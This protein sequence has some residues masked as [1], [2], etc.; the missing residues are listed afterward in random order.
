VT[1]IPGDG[2][3]PEVAE[4]TR[5]VLDASGAAFEWDLQDA[6]YE[7]WEREGT[8]VPDSTLASLRTRRLALKGPTKTPLGGFRPVN[9][10]FRREFDLYAGVR[11]SRAYPGVPTRFPETD[12]V[13]VRMTHEDLYAGIEYPR[14]EAATAELRELVER[15]DGAQIP[16]D[17]GISIKALSAA[18]SERIARTAFEYVREHGRRRVTAVHKANVIK[19]SD[20]LF[21]DAVRKVAEE[22][23]PD[24]P[25]DD[26]RID[27]LCG[28]LVMH[29][30]EFDVLVMPLMYGDIV[31]DI[32]AGLTGG[33]GMAPGANFGDDCAV[34]EAVHGT[35]PR[36]AGQ[37]RVNPTGLI[38]SGVMMLRHLGEDDAAERVERA[39][40][41]VLEEG[42]DV[43]Y[44]LKPSRDDPS[45]VGTAGFA[46]AV[47][48]ACGLSSASLP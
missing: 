35:A 31:S 13:V 3:G 15:T 25:F 42:R 34:F 14:G 37:N 10:T 7:V 8:P 22:E 39:L 23:Y 21:L 36:H 27:S 5:R 4:A 1:L 6:G 19:H 20:G 43:T 28:E 18:A 17:S 2:V 32:G 9:T 11:P 45:A 47:I 44:D 29:P 40:A 41:A 38:L 24:I 33:L 26:R 48:A 30:G 46:D 16:A 12:L